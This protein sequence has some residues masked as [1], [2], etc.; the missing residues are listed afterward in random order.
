MEKYSTILKYT[1]ITTIILGT[2]CGLYGYSIKTRKYCIICGTI[3]PCF[4][5]TNCKPNS[6]EGYILK[7]LRNKRII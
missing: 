7:F 1:G 6:F 5:F 4:I 3:P 2:I